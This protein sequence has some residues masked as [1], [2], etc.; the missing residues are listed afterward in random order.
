[1]LGKMIPFQLAGYA[2]PSTD[3]VFSDYREGLIPVYLPDMKYPPN[4]NGPFKL[5]YAS[6]SIDRMDKGPITA[7]LIY[8]IN[9]DY[10]K[11]N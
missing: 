4:G 3:T 8:E 1:M 5:V 9:K 11:L 7:I 10:K 2:H 6:P